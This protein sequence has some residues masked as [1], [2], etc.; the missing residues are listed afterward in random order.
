MT[1]RGPAD[2]TVAGMPGS[3]VL[4]DGVGAVVDPDAAGRLGP[5]DVGDGL[6][7][8][9]AEAVVCAARACLL[10]VIA[11]TS[12]DR[13]RENDQQPGMPNSHSGQYYTGFDNVVSTLASSVRRAAPID[14]GR[15][16]WR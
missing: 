16:P 1:T 15:S 5:E 4:L 3:D 2:F 11:A 12:R 13:E 6:V 7:E 10:M 9:S 14:S 8:G